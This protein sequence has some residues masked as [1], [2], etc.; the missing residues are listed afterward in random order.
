[1]S[2]LALPDLHRA[3]RLIRRGHTSPV[4]ITDGHSQILGGGPAGTFVDQKARVSGNAAEFPADRLYNKG[5]HAFL[6]YSEQLHYGVITATPPH[7]FADMLGAD[8]TVSYAA[9]FPIGATVALTITN[10]GLILLAVLN[11]VLGTFVTHRSMEASSRL[12]R[13]LVVSTAG[14]EGLLAGTL[15]LIP[16]A[17]ILAAFSISIKME[18]DSLRT[19]YIIYGLVLLFLASHITAGAAIGLLTF[20]HSKFGHAVKEIVAYGVSLAATIG[21]VI[22]LVELTFSDRVLDLSSWWEVA[23]EFV[24]TLFS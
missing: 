3:I 4:V 22:K 9:T 6:T 23:K 20:F 5:D 8:G 1:M 16:I 18:S 15:S 17:A 12:G 19:M 21:F 2:F 7:S 11:H 10:L 14:L 13:A 24:H